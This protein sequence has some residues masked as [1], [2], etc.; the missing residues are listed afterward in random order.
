MFNLASDCAGLLWIS[1]PLLVDTR[2]LPFRSRV[3]LEESVVPVRLAFIVRF[4]VGEIEFWE[5]ILSL[6]VLCY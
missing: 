4:S 3:A 1:L 2:K 5:C 6:S